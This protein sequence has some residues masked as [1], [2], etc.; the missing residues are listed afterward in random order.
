MSTYEEVFKAWKAE[1]A[2]EGLT[3]LPEGFYGRVA[4]LIAAVRAGLKMADMST[5]KARLAKEELSNLEK[6]VEEI[7]WARVEKAIK[8]LLEGRG[9]EVEKLTPEER[10][11]LE[12]V[13]A[14]F[15]ELRRFSEDLLRGELRRPRS[16]RTAGLEAPSTRAPLARPRSVKHGLMLV[17]ILADVPAIVGPDLRAHG[18][19]KRGDVAFIPVENALALIRKGLAVEVELREGA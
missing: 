19:F 6:M 9:L 14:S 5:L 15:L 16:T 12:P 18:P 10:E 3:E 8:A 13:E 2:S 17:R 1:V 4:E 11:L 7:F